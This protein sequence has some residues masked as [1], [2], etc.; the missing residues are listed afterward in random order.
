MMLSAAGL[1][2]LLSLGG[3]AFF[4]LDEGNL[5]REGGTGSMV[6]KRDPYVVLGIVCLFLFLVCSMLA[7]AQSFYYIRTYF[8]N[9]SLVEQDI[10]IKSLHFLELPFREIQENHGKS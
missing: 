1:S 9:E 5:E 4:G 8:C 3:W 10:M 7:E 6:E 2:A